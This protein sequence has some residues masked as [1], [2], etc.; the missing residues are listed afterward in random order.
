MA[1][2][3]RTLGDLAGLDALSVDA[4]VVPMFEG[5]LQPQGVAG[6][7]DWRLSGR[8]ARLF[9]A[10]TFRGAKGESVL[11]TSLDRLGAERLFLYGLGP[12]DAWMK[13]PHADDVAPIVKMIESASVASLALAPP[14][15][16]D[17]VPNAAAVM[18]TWRAAWASCA[19]PVVQVLDTDGTLVFLGDK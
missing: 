13:A 15:G 16:H 6:N 18:K 14:V 9:L 5:R 19:L 4:V 3:E 10:G 12:A 2:L 8:L 7:I 17:G 1:R 11:M